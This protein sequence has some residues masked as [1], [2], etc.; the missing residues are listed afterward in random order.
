[1]EIELLFKV[2]LHSQM[3]GG[4][5]GIAEGAQRRARLLHPSIA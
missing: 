3:S 1:M 2:R 5:S 4:D